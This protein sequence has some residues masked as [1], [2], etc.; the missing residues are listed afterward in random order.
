MFR[1]GTAAQLKAGAGALR[2]E[3]LGEKPIKFQQVPAASVA[4]R[5]VNGE[6]RLTRPSEIFS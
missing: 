1:N 5:G 3:P 4:H 2:S 6:D